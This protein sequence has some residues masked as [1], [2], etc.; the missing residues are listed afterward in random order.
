MRRFAQAN[1][2]SRTRK[3]YV[4]RNARLDPDWAQVKRQTLSIAGRAISTLIQTQGIGDLYRLYAV[5]LRD[6]VDFNLANI[7]S[8]FTRTPSMPFER[9]YMNALFKVGYEEAKGG[10]PWS[11]FPPGFD[12][13]EQETVSS[14]PVT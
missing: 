10:Y 6:G 13:I 1:N 12:S 9:S 8:T 5:S 2:A 4:I 11:K 14:D 7:P 3:L